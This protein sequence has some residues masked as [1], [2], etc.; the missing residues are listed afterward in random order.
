MNDR[1]HDANRR[2]EVAA[3]PTAPALVLRPWSV[4]DVPELVEIHRDPVLRRW[5][6]DPLT[7]PD[8]T[9][10]WLRDQERSWADGD[11][12]AFAVL[13]DGPE[14]AAERVAGHVVLKEVAAGKPSADVGYW[15]AAWARGRG[16][17]PRA[18]EALTGWA[19]DTFGD[20]G[21][22][23][24]DLLHQVD[25]AASCR[26]A[27]K[28]GY[29]FDRLLPPAPPAFPREGHVHT[30]HFPRLPRLGHLAG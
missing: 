8:D 6:V 10:R 28:T 4:A 23:R 30:R 27:E 22:A 19:F 17:A 20:T 2:L 25:N 15:T 11:R 29:A 9:L 7:S 18:L 13:T 24:L 5:S 1:P 16:V 14:G 12:F 21:L 26:V 3:T